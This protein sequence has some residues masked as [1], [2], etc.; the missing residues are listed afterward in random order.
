MP[1]L[2]LTPR[3]SDDSQALWKAAAR[4][5]WSIERLHGWRVP[6]HL[7]ALEEPVF[8]GEAL[9]AP[10]LGA[11]LGL[12]LDN[13]P[14]DWLPTLPYEYRLR[15]IVLSTLGAQRA[16]TEPAF[17]KPPNDKSFPANVYTGAGLPQ[18]YDEE[19]P[20]LVA[21]IVR[22]R[23]ELR[24]FVLDRRLR[25]WSLYSRHGE[26]ARDSGFA[27]SEEEDAQ[28]TAFLQRMLDDPRVA[29]PRACVIDVGCIEDRGWACV[30]QNA[31]WGAGLYACDAQLALEV[32]RYASVR[33][34]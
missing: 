32:I 15:E 10:E 17:V 12:R 26:L 29:L 19:M 4:Q 22:W 21:E 1:T 16:R 7:R 14:E 20:V 6:E 25:T 33:E 34:G 9:F 30:E 18:G 13:P 28:A 5:G 23:C 31:A 11:A 8:Y 24:C 2:I 3:H 27:S